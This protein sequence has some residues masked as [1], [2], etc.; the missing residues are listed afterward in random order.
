MARLGDVCLINPKPD[1]LEDTLQVSFVPMQK[2]SETGDIDVSEIKLFWEVKKGFTAFRDGDVL[3]IGR[4]SC[5][6]RV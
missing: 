3:Q 4:A 5:R 1:L 2:V 6:E